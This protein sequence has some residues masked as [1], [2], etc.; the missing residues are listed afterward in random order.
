[1]KA[2]ITTAVRQWFN[3][4]CQGLIRLAMATGVCFTVTA[5]YGVPPDMREDWYEPATPWDSTR[6]NDSVPSMRHEQQRQLE[7]R[8]EQMAQQ[9][10]NHVENKYN[11]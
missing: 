5:C 7:E 6:L 2:K 11:Q 3:S 8:V 10:A 4:S 9:Q 1:M